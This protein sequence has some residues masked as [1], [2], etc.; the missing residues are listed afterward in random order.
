M[1][2]EGGTITNKDALGAIGM[3]KY[4][5]TFNTDGTATLS[6]GAQ[7]S[8]GTYEITDGSK[9]SFVTAVATLEG[10]YSDAQ[11]TLTSGDLQYIFHKEN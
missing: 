8:E 5:I 3:D 6:T 1:T 2:V 9:Y 4:T 7:A 11:V 10:T